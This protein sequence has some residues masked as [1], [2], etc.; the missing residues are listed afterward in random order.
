VASNRFALRRRI[1]RRHGTG[2]LIVTVSGPGT[3][4]LKGKGLRRVRR[5]AAMAGP[6]ALPV[7]PIPGLARRLARRH[8]TRV[9]VTVAFR[10]DGGTAR[11]RSVRLT[12]WKEAGR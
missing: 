12:L 4:T 5:H 10:P 9:D 6:V 8:R 2:T 7:R 1:D 11:R 3:L